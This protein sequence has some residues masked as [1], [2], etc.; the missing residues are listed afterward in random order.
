MQRSKF[1]YTARSSALIIRHAVCIDERRA[2]FRQDLIG[3]AIVMDFHRHHHLREKVAPRGRSKE[4]TD[5]KGN[6]ATTSA[7][8]TE[9][10]TAA[11]A[12]GQ[13]GRFRRPSQ[14]A[15]R[16]G[17]LSVPDVGRRSTSPSKSLGPVPEK[18][19]RSISSAGSYLSLQMQYDQLNGG[20]DD[21]EA[22]EDQKQDIEEVWFPGG[23][24]VRPCVP[25]STLLS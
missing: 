4:K 7:K 21:M 11:N 17:R 22:E 5:E 8:T 20:D 13:S 23:H 24:G 18:D 3:E 2:K 10:L 12:V 6:K 25:S 9:P 14:V 16:H 15:T 19:R 1:P